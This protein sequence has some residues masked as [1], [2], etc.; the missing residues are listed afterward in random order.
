LRRLEHGMHVVFYREE[1]SGILVS[2]ILHQRMLY[3]ESR[4]RGVVCPLFLEK[5][6]SELGQKQLRVCYSCCFFW[7]L[8][9]SIGE[10][11]GH[12]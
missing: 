8:S 2:R 9:M 4:R 10:T 6:L 12:C 5:P 1:R 11:K 7:A 3:R